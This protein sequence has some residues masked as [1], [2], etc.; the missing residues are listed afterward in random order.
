MKICQPLF[1]AALPLLW[2]N[3]K[4]L[5]RWDRITFC[6]YSLFGHASK[7]LDTITSFIHSAFYIYIY[8][9]IFSC[10]SSLG[11]K[12]C[13]E[14]ELFL[15][16]NEPRWLSGWHGT[17]TLVFHRGPQQLV[18]NQLWS[19]TALLRK[20]PVMTTSGTL[21]NALI[22]DSMKQKSIHWQCY[23]C[24]PCPWPCSRLSCYCNYLAAAFPS[25]ILNLLVPNCCRP[26]AVI[27]HLA[28]TC[29]HSF[30]SQQAHA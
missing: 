25:C 3:G 10:L 13:S 21:S 28:A 14:G 12:S 7:G 18:L 30:P 5:Q 20:V 9:Y 26:K 24:R 11:S 6:R 4:S 22:R 1:T 29:Y 15:Y 23:W 8:I 19:I 17:Q 2:W 16:W 27:S